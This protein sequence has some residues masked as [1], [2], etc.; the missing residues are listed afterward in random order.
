[1]PAPSSIPR[2]NEPR[3]SIARRIR[4]MIAGNAGNTNGNIPRTR[5]APRSAGNAGNAAGGYRGSRT[6]T[7]YR[8]NRVKWD[9]PRARAQVR[10]HTSTREGSG[11]HLP[12]NSGVPGAA[13]PYGGGARGGALHSTPRIGRRSDAKRV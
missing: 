7:T 6:R 5:P 8:R 1:M 13:L 2:T 3:T 11:R 10:A 12:R 4:R 9:T